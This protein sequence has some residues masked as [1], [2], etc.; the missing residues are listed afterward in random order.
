M[1]C[2]IHLYKEKFIGGK[3]ITA[4]T[5]TP[6]E[7]EKD[8]MEVAW[9]NRYHARNYM[10]FG[11]LAKGVREEHPYSFKARDLPFN[12]C[13]EARRES[14]RWDGDGHNHS[15]LYLHEL[16]EMRSYLDTVTV[17]VEG[18]KDQEELESLRASIAS[19]NPDWRLLFPYCAWTNIPSYVRFEI[20]VPA[21]FYMGSALDEIIHG[22]DGIDGENHRIV[23]WFDN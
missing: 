22:F 4:D 18:M 10:L 15:H 7:Y 12:M 23:F 8:R 16:R 20:D 1:G 19:G 11:L 9:E 6:D 14:E 21:S 13:I 5:W 17:H 2:D 3:W